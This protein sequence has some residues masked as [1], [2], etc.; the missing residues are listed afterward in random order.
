M[1]AISK[2]SDQTAGMRRLICG[3]AGRTYQIVRK[4]HGSEVMK[5]S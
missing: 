3:C 5:F 1:Q 4:S 2:G